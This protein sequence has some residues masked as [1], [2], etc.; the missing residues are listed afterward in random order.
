[1]AGYILRNYA[2]SSPRHASTRGLS[3]AELK[4]IDGFIEERIEFGF[5]VRDLAATVG[6]GPQEFS[7]KLSLAV[8]LSPW[9]YVNSVRLAI[10]MRLLRSSRVSI[11]NIAGR[12]GFVDQSHFTNVFRRASGITPKAF[13]D[14]A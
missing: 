2:E 7:Q 6:L 9:R 3:D 8:G 10:A 4:K 5:S 12:L 1:L 13:R 11:A 14:R